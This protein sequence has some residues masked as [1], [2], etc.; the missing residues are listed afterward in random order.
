[1]ILNLCPQ[2]S[3]FWRTGSACFVW[4][5]NDRL[6]HFPKKTKYLW[7]E[8][9]Q[10]VDQGGNSG[11]IMVMYWKE[12]CRGCC[13]WVTRRR[14]ASRVPRCSSREDAPSSCA[15]VLQPGQPRSSSPLVLAAKLLTTSLQRFPD[16][17]VAFPEKLLRLDHQTVV[18]RK[19]SATWSRSKLIF[20]HFKNTNCG[21]CLDYY[22]VNW[23]KSTFPEFVFFWKVASGSLKDAEIIHNKL[24]TSHFVF[25]STLYSYNNFGQ[26]LKVALRQS[27]L[28]VLL[29]GSYWRL[30]S[31]H[32][33]AA[34]CISCRDRRRL[35]VAP[36]TLQQQE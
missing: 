5:I 13:C 15:G 35:G 4:K 1:M 34:F 9:W 2:L 16:R 17:F 12:S 6:T 8:T 30:Q 14:G 27:I 20:W 7:K 19:T 32:G 22:F 26:K 33:C 24:W 25:V 29:F 31:P 21:S 23:P 3:S 10:S 18:M 36:T 11:R 28:T